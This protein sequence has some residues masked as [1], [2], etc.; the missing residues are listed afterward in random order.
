[1]FCHNTQE[2]DAS[3]YCKHVVVGAPKN[4]L[5]V[6]PG[7]KANLYELSD[8]GLYRVENSKAKNFITVKCAYSRMKNSCKDCPAKRRIYTL[9]DGSTYAENGPKAGQDCHISP[10]CF[11]QH[12]A[13][14]PSYLEHLVSKSLDIT[15]EGHALI[16][17]MALLTND[18]RKT[19]AQILKAVQDLIKQ[20][21]SENP[22]ITV[23]HSLG[24]AK[25]RERV[26]NARFQLNKIQ[27]CVE[28]VQR[29]HGFEGGSGFLRYS[30]TFVDDG[31]RAKNKTQ[32]MLVFTKP[33]LL[34]CFRDKDVSML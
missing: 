25:V 17:E 22:G 10:L 28:T 31:K 8:G 26:N 7:P 24:Q 14:V 4:A 19:N 15:S 18:N 6:K 1:M 34:K 9:P 16:D 29:D 20:R 23:K 3:S 30:A 2:K 33:G 5:S 12:N 13:E 32:M 27:N 11:T 21:R